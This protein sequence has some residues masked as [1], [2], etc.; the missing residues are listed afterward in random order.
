MYK[1]IPI[2]L[3]L[4]ACD[5]SPERYGGLTS[6]GVTQMAVMTGCPYDQIRVTD[7]TRGWSTATWNVNC[8]LGTFACKNDGSGNSCE[9]V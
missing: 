4:A 5:T 6:I 3:L 2:I 1:F 9:K 8:T 7:M